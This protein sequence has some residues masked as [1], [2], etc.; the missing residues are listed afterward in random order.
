MMIDVVSVE[1]R[2]GKLLQEV[3]LFVGRA[4]RT[5]AP[6]ELPPKVSRTSR[7]R[8][9]KVDKRLSRKPE[10]ADHSC[11]RAVASAVPDGR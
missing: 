1:D 10:P 5:I 9:A 7:K 6:I 4:R 8:P 3:A 2:P 11:G